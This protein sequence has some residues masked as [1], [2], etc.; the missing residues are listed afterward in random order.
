MDLFTSLKQYM[1]S[2]LCRLQA[3]RHNSLPQQ[4]RPAPARPRAQ[5]GEPRDGGGQ[6]QVLPPLQEQIQAARSADLPQL[7]MRQNY[8]CI[9]EGFKNSCSVH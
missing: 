8:W 4:P 5:P 9:R 7:H 6:P 1:Y 3:P 2:R